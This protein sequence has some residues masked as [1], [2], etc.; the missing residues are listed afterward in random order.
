[1]SE[2]KKNWWG[3]NWK[4]VV[5]VGCLSPLVLIGI[6]VTVIFM[7]VSGMMKSSDV[8][9]DAVSKAKAHPTVQEEIG[10]PIKEGGLISGNLNT[11]GP[12]GE[13]NLSIPLSGPKGKAAVHVVATKS[14]GLWTYSTLSV[15]LKETGQRI[16]LLSQGGQP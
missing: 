7:S 1:M 2:Q 9:K 10:S 8:Y 11:S 16:D 3:R 15:E 6:L 5:P 12:S 13:A 4:W 14:A